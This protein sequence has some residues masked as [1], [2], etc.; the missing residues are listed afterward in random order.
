MLRSALPV[1]DDAAASPCSTSTTAAAPATAAPTAQRLN[2]RWGIV[3]VDDC[4]NG[5]RY[6]VAQGL[7]DRRALAIR[8]GSAGGYTTLAALAF[9]DAFSAG[10]SH[11][12]VSDL[13]SAGD[14]TRTSSSRA[15]STAS[16]GPY[17]ERTRR[18]HA[19]ARRSTTSTASPSR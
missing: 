9:R 8:G 19:S 11:F 1:L 18:L 4:V 14:A 5:A 10:A 17:P 12:G 15:T 3:D 16:I 6:L 7:V 2:G 13:E